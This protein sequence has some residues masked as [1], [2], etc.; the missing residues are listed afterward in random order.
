[1]MILVLLGFVVLAEF[2]GRR[3]GLAEV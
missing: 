3:F 1:M 2:L